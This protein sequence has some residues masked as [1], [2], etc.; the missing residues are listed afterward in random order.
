LRHIS[1]IA[2]VGALACATTRARAQSQNS[3]LEV[4]VTYNATRSLQAGA[5]QN[6]WQ[7]GGSAEV[8]GT[9]WKSLAIVADVTGTHTDSINNT[10][11]PLSLV[12]TTFGPRYRFMADHKIS[13]YGQALFGIANGFDSLFPAPGGVQ[14]SANSMALQI[15]GGVDLRVNKHLAVRAIDAGWLRTQLPNATA[16]VQNNLRLG[17]GLIFRLSR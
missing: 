7:Q 17:A 1:L 4:A 2:T 8:S 3:R 14:S 12:T 9:V 10:G 5:N 6:F 13:P 16:N 11:I 15:G